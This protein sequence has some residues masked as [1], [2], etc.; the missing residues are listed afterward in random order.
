[1]KVKGDSDGRRKRGEASMSELWKNKDRWWIVDGGWW[2][3]EKEVLKN[4]KDN[5]RRNQ[6]RER[7]QKRG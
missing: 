5:I 4:G 7:S 1:M 2:D 3:E 6:G